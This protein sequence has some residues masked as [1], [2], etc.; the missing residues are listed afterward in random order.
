MIVPIDDP[1]VVALVAAA[2][3]RGEPVVIPTDTVY[4]LAA[5][6]ADAAAVARLFAVKGRAPDTPMAVLCA[7]VDQALALADPD[8]AAAARAAAERFWP[9]PLTMVLRRR[10]GVDLHL[11]EPHDTIGLRVPDH[12]LVRRLA[13]EVGPVAATSANRHGDPPLTSAQA[14]AD[15]L[16]DA[17]ALVVD[18][19]ELGDAASTVVD[20]TGPDW[21]VLREGPLFGRDVVAMAGAPTDDRQ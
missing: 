13:A 2:L 9:G 16:A 21:H 3:T 5:L 14:V 11:G 7:G 4:G 8:S 17:V 6:P 10:A 1:A 20:A 12:E 19:G 18:A 15:T